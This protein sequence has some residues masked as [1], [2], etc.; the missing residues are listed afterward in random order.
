MTTIVATLEGNIIHFQKPITF[1]HPQKVLVT[2][3][4]VSDEY[5]E[6]MKLSMSNLNSAYSENEP[7]YDAVQIREANPGYNT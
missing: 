7:D 3:L 5:E 6:W 2:F 1:T 4:E